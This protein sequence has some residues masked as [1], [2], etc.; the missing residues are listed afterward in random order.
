MRLPK[1]GLCILLLAMLIVSSEA[2]I[3]KDTAGP[4]TVEFNSSQSYNTR[5]EFQEPEQSGYSYWLLYLID[6]AGHE[7]GWISFRSYSYPQKAS[8]DFLDE[9]LNQRIKYFQVTSPTKTPATVDGTEARMGEGYS[10]V[11]SRKWRGVA[12]AYKPS[13]DSFTNTNT[14]KHFINFDSL[15][16]PAEFD[17]IVS[18]IHVTNATYM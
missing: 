11:Y 1:L 3:L 9:M 12:W 8:K 14:S 17:Q 6:S 7:V 15:Q 18:S 16:D 2:T 4:W 10:S 13:F 5:Y